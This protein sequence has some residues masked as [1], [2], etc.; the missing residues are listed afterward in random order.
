MEK[1]SKNIF[2][3]I[4]LTY[5]ILIALGLGI[6]VGIMLQGNPDI[7]DNYIKPFGTIFLNLI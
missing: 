3:R 7:A 5:Q 4:P 2:A 6:A 1:K